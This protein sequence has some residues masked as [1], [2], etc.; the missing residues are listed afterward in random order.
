MLPLN[1]RGE[2]DKF[3][4]K[5]LQRYIKKLQKERGFCEKYV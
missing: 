2:A 4:V 1:S 5:I 3:C